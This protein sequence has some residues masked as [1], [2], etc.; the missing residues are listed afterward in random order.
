M[1]QDLTFVNLR[2]SKE[3]C[4]RRLM[5][6]HEGDQK[7]LETFGKFMDIFDLGDDPNEPNVIHIDIKPDMSREEVVEVILKML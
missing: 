2:L 1:G 5:V 7:L 4:L 3:E 6:R